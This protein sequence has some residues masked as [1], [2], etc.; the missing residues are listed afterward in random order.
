M[1][2]CVLAQCVAKNGRHEDVLGQVVSWQKAGVPGY[3][4]GTLKYTR[5]GY[6]GKATTCMIRKD[7]KD[8]FKGKNDMGSRYLFCR[9]LRKCEMLRLKVRQK[10]VP[11]QNKNPY[12]RR[13]QR[14]QTKQIISP[15]KAK[16]QRKSEG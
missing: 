1:V 11:K 13:Q 2:H 15:S 5:K 16:Q 7:E 8:K 9:S 4:V 10:A 14:F 6:V 12:L 3:V